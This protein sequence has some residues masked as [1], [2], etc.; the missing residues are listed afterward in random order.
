MLVVMGVTGHC[1]LPEEGDP[2]E[3]QKSP[4]RLLVPFQEY[5]LLGAE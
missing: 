4:L 5:R 2:S 1:L 3:T